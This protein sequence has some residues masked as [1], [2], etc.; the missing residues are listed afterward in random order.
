M[1]FS[2]L[3]WK[4]GRS[5]SLNGMSY[6]VVMKI[7]SGLDKQG[8]IVTWTIVIHH[9]YFSRNLSNRDLVP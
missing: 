6:D 9:Q 7:V 4:R 3:P 5:V 1:E 8:Y 2:S